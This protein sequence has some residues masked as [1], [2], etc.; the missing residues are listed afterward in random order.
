[1]EPSSS[2]DGTLFPD[3][4]WLVEFA[5]LSDPT[6]VAQTVATSLG[7]RESA[8]RPIINLLTDLLYGVLDPRIRFG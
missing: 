4:V 1:M 3:G 7:V 6:L 5:S 8:G 2:S